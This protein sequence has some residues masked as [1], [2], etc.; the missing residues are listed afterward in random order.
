VGGG[1]FWETWGNV[2]RVGLFGRRSKRVEIGDCRGRVTIGLVGKGG[3]DLSLWRSGGGR[4]SDLF[5]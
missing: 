5:F 3:V 1:G 4:G 2:I